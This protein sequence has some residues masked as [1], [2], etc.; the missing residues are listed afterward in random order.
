MCGNVAGASR[1]LIKG[2][3]SFE[4]D[5]TKCSPSSSNADASPARALYWGSETRQY[6]KV[7]GKPTQGICSHT[8]S[9][10][11]PHSSR[12]PSPKVSLIAFT[13]S[14]IFKNEKIEP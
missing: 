2:V 3:R 8:T 5:K 13:P 4:S 1:Y 12:I 10:P 11:A 6:K 14:W 9:L 7:E